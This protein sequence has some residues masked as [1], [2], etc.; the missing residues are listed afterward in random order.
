VL[1]ARDERGTVVSLTGKAR[2]LLWEFERGSLP[3]DIV[4]LLLLLLL[5]VVQPGWLRDPMAIGR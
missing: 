2:V 3:Y 1:V 5:L 4:C